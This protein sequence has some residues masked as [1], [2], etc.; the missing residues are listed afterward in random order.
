MS[1]ILVIDDEAPFARALSIGLRARG[2]EVSWAVT[3]RAGLDVAAQEHPDLALLDLGLPDLDGME[4]LQALRAWTSIPV[5][6]LSA[7]DQEEAKIEALDGGADDYITKPFAM[8]EL[9]ARVRA[10][11]R[12]STPGEEEAIVHTDHFTVDLVAKRVMNAQGQVRLTSTEWQMVELLAK[13]VGKLV[14]QRQML[15]EVWG[16][17][18]E[19]EVDYLRVYMARIRRKLEPNPSRPRYFLTEPG[20]GYRFQLSLSIE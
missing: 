11:L 10:A 14:S 9:V 19:D 5:I 6:V 1:R 2:Y 16:P 18:F 4:V 20:M 8:G 15:R 13:H 17:Q 7:R 3:G 12:H